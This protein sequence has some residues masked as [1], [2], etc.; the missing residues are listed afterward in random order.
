MNFLIMINRFGKPVLLWGRSPLGNIG[1][2]NIG[3]IH[4]KFPSRRKII[5]LR[6]LRE[7]L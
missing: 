4:D 7:D 1:V 6:D 5:L 3:V 2:S